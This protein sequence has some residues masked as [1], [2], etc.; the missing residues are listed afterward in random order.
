MGAVV[1]V[2]LARPGDAEQEIVGRMEF[3]LRISGGVGGDQRQPMLIGRFDQP[4]L[5]RLLDRIA[6][7]AELD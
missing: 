1:A 5:G 7:P 4:R 3:R 2:E 6:A